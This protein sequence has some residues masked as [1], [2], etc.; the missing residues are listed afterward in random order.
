MTIMLYFPIAY[1]DTTGLSSIRVFKQFTNYRRLRDR[2]F[3][4]PKLERFKID[5]Y[6]LIKSFYRLAMIPAKLWL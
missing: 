1:Y 3:E 2:Y 5:V 6:A 4:L